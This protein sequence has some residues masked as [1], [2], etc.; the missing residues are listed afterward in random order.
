[1]GRDSRGDGVS[2]ETHGMAQ[3]L[4]KALAYPTIGLQ[5][6]CRVALAGASTLAEPT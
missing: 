2:C 6:S 4:A 5:T 3:G 1:M